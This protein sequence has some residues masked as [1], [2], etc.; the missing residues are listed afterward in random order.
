M[1]KKFL[2]VDRPVAI[3]NKKPKSALVIEEK[4]GA[5]RKS[6]S[7]KLRMLACTRAYSF[8]TAGGR[9][10]TNILWSIIV[11][12]RMLNTAKQRYAGDRPWIDD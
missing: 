8:C 1:C 6:F 10:W 5:S 12:F 7:D 3:V 11:A 9:R 4:R 2:F